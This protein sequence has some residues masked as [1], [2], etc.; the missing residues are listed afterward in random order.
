MCALGSWLVVPGCLL[1]LAQASRSQQVWPVTNDQE[2][3]AALQAAAPGDVVQLVPAAVFLDFVLTKG[4][5]VRGPGTIGGVPAGSGV[6]TVTV[7]AGQ[8][9][10]F[11]DVTFALNPYPAAGQASLR[12]TGG[13]VRFERCTI[14]GAA[15]GPALAV[16]SAQVLVQDCQIQAGN[17]VVGLRAVDA[18]L[19]LRDTLV[20]G[21]IAM[22]GVDGARGLECSGSGSLHVSAAQIRGGNGLATHGGVQLQAPAIGLQSSVPT[23][24]ADATLE[25]G[26]ITGPNPGAAALSVT[27]AAAWHAHCAFVGGAGTP[28]GASIVG[29]AYAEP[30]LLGATSSAPLQRGQSTTLRLLADQSGVPVGLLVMTGLRAPILHPLPW[31]PLWLGEVLLVVPG[32]TGGDGAFPLILSVPDDPLLSNQSVHLLGFRLGGGGV[33]LAPLLGG[34]VR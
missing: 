26:S 11:V 18:H 7:P 13:A 8:L 17:G 1:V 33:Q 21:S 20:S 6:R 9:A 4:L 27:G 30:T 10:Q 34:L 32:A 28:P 29:L 25:G 14:L 24:L 5:T 3:Q 12:V 15:V 2:F 16:T 23:W 31:Q 19:C 22:T